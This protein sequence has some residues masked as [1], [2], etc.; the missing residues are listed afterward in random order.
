MDIQTPIT[1]TA[2]DPLDA[3]FDIVAR[4]DALE[5]DVTTIRTDLDEV[6]ARVDKIGRAAQRPALGTGDS[7]PAEVKGFVDATCGAVRF[8]RSS[9][10]PA[11]RPAMAAMP[12][13][14]RSTR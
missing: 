3:S 4:Q 11:P 2:T 8:M 14:A 7:A 12:C 13:R 10:S 5:A 9:R 6:K 1:D